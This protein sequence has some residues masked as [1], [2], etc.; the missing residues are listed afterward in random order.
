MCLI[1]SRPW[2]HWISRMCENI[3]II[4]GKTSYSD[5]IYVSIEIRSANRGERSIVIESCTPNVRRARVHVAI[6]NWTE[7]GICVR[8]RGFWKETNDKRVNGT[9]L[10]S[11]HTIESNRKILEISISTISAVYRTQN[12]FF[13]CCGRADSPRRKSNWLRTSDR[14]RE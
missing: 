8:V 2:A 1:V 12:C 4:V 5:K 6:S 3:I 13:D 9:T 14:P 10:R 7:C 11:P